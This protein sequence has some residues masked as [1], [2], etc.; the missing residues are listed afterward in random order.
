[1]ASIVIDSVS[2]V[3]DVSS[4]VNAIAASGGWFGDGPLAGLALVS[5][6]NEVL[7]V[8]ALASRDYRPD[9]GQMPSV[10]A[11][12]L[13]GVVRRPHCTAPVTCGWGRPWQEVLSRATSAAGCLIGGALGEP[14][15]GRC[16]SLHMRTAEGRVN[17]SAEG[18][19]MTAPVVGERHHARDGRGFSAGSRSRRRFACPN[20][21]ESALGSSGSVSAPVQA[22]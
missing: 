22:T 15:P 2:P 1:M 20:H 13:P 4:L 16:L 17:T 3:P 21:L 18:S 12:G 11:L 6:P 10:F 7:T 19:T 14:T 5:G 8:C 9:R